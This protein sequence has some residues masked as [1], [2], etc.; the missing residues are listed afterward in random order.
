L[1]TRRR[2]LYTGAVAATGAAAIGIDGYSEANHPQVTQLEIPLARLPEAFDGFTIAQLSDFHY[3]DHFSVVP[4]RKAVQVV[5]ELHP[6]LIVLTGDFVTVPFFAHRR[7][8]YPQSAKNA[9]PALTHCRAFG[10]LWA[11]SPFLEIMMPARILFGSPALCG[12]MG[13]PSC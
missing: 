5:N 13:F 3:E 9:E 8:H 12:T 10:L 1:L 11:D 2:F 6:D 4:I 7:R